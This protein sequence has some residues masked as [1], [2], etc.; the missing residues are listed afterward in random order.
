MPKEFKQLTCQEKNNDF[1][2]L[3]QN[4]WKGRRTISFS[5]LYDNSII[6][7]IANGQL[8]KSCRPSVD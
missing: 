7:R 8:E 1:T 2:L 4:H 3:K 5:G 6:K